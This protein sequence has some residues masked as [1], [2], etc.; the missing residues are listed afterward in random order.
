LVKTAEFYYPEV[1]NNLTTAR[2]PHIHSGSAYKTWWAQK[3]GINPK[4]IVIVSTMPCTSK[5]YEARQSRLNTYKDVA[6][7]DYVL[8]TRELAV[9]FKIRNIDF[10]NLEGSNADK[11]AEYSGAAAIYGA[12]G[13]V[14]ESAL[15]SA[16]KNIT[17]ENLKN[18]ELK[19][20]R[21]DVDGIK[22]AEINIKGRKI[23]V[24]VA[25]TPANIKKI[26]EEI[27]E[28]PEAYHY[29]ECMACNGGCIGGGGQP[30][31]SSNEIISKRIAALYKI[32]DK[33]KIRTAHDNPVLQ[34]YAIWVESKKDKELKDSVYYRGFSKKDKFE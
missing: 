26:I 23:R 1:L 2:S 25:A 7:V 32:D 6:P 13:G 14:M 11:Y 5:K 8:T 22:T 31:P 17:G 12:S 19:K 20:V 21:A 34:E 16:Y 24:A 33:K 9:L 18:F 3:E 4:D 15:R 28:N 30:N 29:V 27:R 10:A